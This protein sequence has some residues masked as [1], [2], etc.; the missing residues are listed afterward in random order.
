[1]IIEQNISMWIQVSP[2]VLST[3]ETSVPQR[4]CDVFPLMYFDPSHSYVHPSNSSA[5]HLFNRFGCGA[6]GFNIDFINS[7]DNSVQNGDIPSS[8]IGKHDRIHKQLISNATAY[9]NISFV[10]SAWI[11]HFRPNSQLS[12]GIGHPNRVIFHNFEDN[13]ARDGGSISTVDNVCNMFR[14]TNRRCVTMSNETLDA[15]SDNSENRL[16][17]FDQPTSTSISCLARRNESGHNVDIMW[18]LVQLPVQYIW[19]P[20]WADFDVPQSKHD[21]VCLYINSYCTV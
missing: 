8:N 7:T 21:K 4:H 18:Q 19:Y 17:L 11:S 5:H 14:D 2:H 20:Y 6:S 1:M 10:V 3:A 13:G 9:V 16:P 12:G 15:V